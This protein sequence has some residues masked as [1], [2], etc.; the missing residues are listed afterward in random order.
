MNFQIN[1]IREMPIE[2]AKLLG[3]EKIVKNLKTFLESENM[4]TP[5][6]IAIH[7]EWG[8][9]KT[10][11]MKTLK[12]NLDNTK[13]T[14]LFFEAWKYEYSNPSLGL[15]A[16]IAEKY[17]TEDAVTSIIRAGV[18]IFSQKYFGVEPDK[19]TQYM[20][21][22][23]QHTE[24]LS[25][26][27]KEIIKNK[28]GEGKLIIIIDDLDR[29]DVEN[30][31]Q[32]LAIIK[33]FFDV[34]N[35]VCIAAVDFERLKQAWR[36]K[37]L[38]DNSSKDGSK[39][40]SEDGSQYLDK[41]FQIRIGI[42]KPP[43]EQIK[44]YVKTLIKDLPDSVSELFAGF[45]SKNPRSIKRTL[46]LISYRQNLLTSENKEIS[47]ILWTLLEE[48]ISNN[49]IIYLHDH[50]KNN[51]SSIGHCIKKETKLEAVAVDLRTPIKKDFY[52]KYAEKLSVF[53]DLSYD[54]CRQYEITKKE[55]DDD[56][57]I[58]YSATNESLH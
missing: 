7:G 34:E 46:N 27:L 4:I 38:I 26:R 25:K 39:D 11:I 51:G 57:Q 50:L 56:F 33:L 3:H 22:S 42:P 45:L 53:F 17:A 1:P 9:G 30:S 37:Y 16:E 49:W 14:V 55:L 40:G 28:V 20:R 29:C 12:K 23:K 58:L 19:I 21:A 54:V 48:I 2:D 43:E 52:T 41:I 6:S 18:Y 44:E 24:T 15:I 10:S 32:L 5:L 31:L 47:A 36:Q 35:C 13:F 8:S